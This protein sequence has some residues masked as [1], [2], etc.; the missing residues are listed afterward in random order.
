MMRQ[1]IFIT[2]ITLVYIPVILL[3]GTYIACADATLPSLPEGTGLAAN[4]PGDTG[5]GEDAAVVFTENFESY[6]DSI[7][8][9]SSRWSDT[10]RDGAYIVR[11][12]ENVNSGSKALEHVH[13]ET[14]KGGGAHKTL[15]SGYDTLHVRY[16]MKYHEQFPGCHHAG[17]VGISSKSY[18][19]AGT[20][21]NGSNL[22]LVKPDALAPFF[23]WSP[24]GNMP[25]GFL[26][27]YVYH[28]DQNSIYGSQFLPSGRVLGGD[29]NF[30]SS[31]VPKPDI[32][33]ERG[34]WYC[35]ELMVMLNTP[36][37]RDGRIALWID[38][39][40]VGDWHNIRFRTVNSLKA[41]QLWFST[42]SSQI[43]ENKIIWFDDIVA[44]T[45]YIGPMTG[46]GSN[47]A[48]NNAL[49]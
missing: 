25:P 40:I 36:D 32:I 14:L 22:F 44:A 6:M 33:L 10:R 19:Q 29:I 12:P 39:K 38:G 7:F 24:S 21:P 27:V 46:T 8:L 9:G 34:R 26:H 43:H 2:I 28:M 30:G 5:I 13:N 49:K 31:F 35:Y 4:Y 45:S 17:G 20:K 41:D 3:S 48:D 1:S 16:Y 11:Q 42:Y 23:S 47:E 18:T 37:K 15:S